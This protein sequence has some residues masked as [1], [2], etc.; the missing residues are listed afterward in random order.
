MSKE[1]VEAILGA[2]K[3]IDGDRIRYISG[4]FVEYTSQNEVFAIEVAECE[5]F[6]VTYHGAIILK[7]EAEAAVAFI[8]REC[9][10]C[11]D[12]KNVKGYQ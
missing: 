2:P 9:S 11:E 7:M 6:V 10:E 4:F 8:K 5:E 3:R 1:E 12:D